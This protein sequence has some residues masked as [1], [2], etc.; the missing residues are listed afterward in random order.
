MAKARGLPSCGFAVF[1]DKGGQPPLLVERRAKGKR[2]TVISGVRGN[3]RA[4]CTALTTLLGVGGTVHAKGAL[5]DVEVQ[6][7]QVERVA[8]A[9]TQLGCL[10]GP[11]GAKAPAPATVVERGCGY[12]SFLKEEEGTRKERKER[13]R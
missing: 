3:A 12:D 1:A 9:L 4:L 5:A 7:E 6:G 11:T 8:Q 10:R 2:V 13:H